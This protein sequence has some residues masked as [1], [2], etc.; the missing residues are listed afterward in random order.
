MFEDSLV[1]STGRIKTRLWTKIVPFGFQFL[2]VHRHHR[3]HRRP[4][5]LLL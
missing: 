4:R 2:L 3:H 1:E 5:P